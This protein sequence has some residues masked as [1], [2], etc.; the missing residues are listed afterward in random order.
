MHFTGGASAIAHV[1]CAL[2]PAAFER[3]TRMLFSPSTTL[4]ARRSWNNRSATLSP[5]ARSSRFVCQGLWKR[6]FYVCIES[7]RK[8]VKSCEAKIKK[9]KSSATVAEALAATRSLQELLLDGVAFYTA[10]ID[11]LVHTFELT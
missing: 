1:G 4:L 2:S 7:Q 3:P 5:Q 6:C 9:D 10:F 8:K 11:R